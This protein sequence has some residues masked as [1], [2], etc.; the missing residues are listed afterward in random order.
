MGDPVKERRGHTITVRTWLFVALLGV[1]FMV[2]PYVYKIVS[3]QF[4]GT[5]RPIEQIYAPL[6]VASTE[7]RHV[8]QRNFK[9]L[10]H[11]APVVAAFNILDKNGGRFHT[12]TA[13][14]LRASLIVT[15]NHV[16]SP[17]AQTGIIIENNGR[18][19]FLV[20]TSPIDDVAFLLSDAPYPELVV[21]TK[22]V[23]DVFSSFHRAKRVLLNDVLVGMKCMIY[24]NP[25]IVLGVLESWDP[26]TNS[27]SFVAK[28]DTRGCSGAPVFIIDEGR[29]AVIGIYQLQYGIISW[30]TDINE[31]IEAAKVL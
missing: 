20:D 28:A 22:P 15:A 17:P 7:E 6:G 16:V 23:K 13:F 25:P 2:I 9:N 8:L 29:L 11:G 5:T 14:F 27:F 12:A 26:Q 10:L 19:A 24:P 3:D 30:A 1:I 31:V 4:D 21:K 18:P